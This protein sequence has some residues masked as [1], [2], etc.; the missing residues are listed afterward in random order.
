MMD[1]VSKD[2]L[3]AAAMQIILHA[4]DCRNLNE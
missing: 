3:N 1:H 2:E 4:G